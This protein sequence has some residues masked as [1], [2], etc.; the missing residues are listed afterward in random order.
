MYSYQL[1]PIGAPMPGLYVSEE[2]SSAGDKKERGF[3]F[4]VKGGKPRSTISWMVT[5]VWLQQG[6]DSDDEDSEDVVL[7][8]EGR[9]NDN[10]LTTEEG[11]RIPRSSAREV[12]ESWGA[13]G[14]R[15]G[16]DER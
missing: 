7:G 4:Y 9:A 2:I 16:L 3:S 15:E 10:G 12:V 1:T 5:R 11:T 8:R 13:S 14:L 6:G